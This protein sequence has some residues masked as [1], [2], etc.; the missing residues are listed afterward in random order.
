MSENANLDQS[1]DEDANIDLT[2][3]D[4]GTEYR[5]AGDGGISSGCSCK[6]NILEDSE[7]LDGLVS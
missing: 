4:L 2:I 6:Q 5:A 7:D 3:T 1:P